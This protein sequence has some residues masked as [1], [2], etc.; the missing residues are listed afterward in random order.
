MPERLNRLET[1]LSGQRWDFAS[2][3]HSRLPPRKSVWAALIALALLGSA[4]VLKFAV[5]DVAGGRLPPFIFL[6]AQK[7]SGSLALFTAQNLPVGKRPDCGHWRDGSLA[8]SSRSFAFYPSRLCC[9][10]SRMPN[11]MIHC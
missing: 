5:D 11:R 3:F 1:I 9:G 8:P 7:W 10:H 4:V 6:Y 2:R